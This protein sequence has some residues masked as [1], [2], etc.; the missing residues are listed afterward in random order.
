MKKKILMFKMVQPSGHRIYDAVRCCTMPYDAVKL[1]K[2]PAL[3]GPLLAG[4]RV[5]KIEYNSGKKTLQR[6]K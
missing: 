3:P 5:K 1:G 6:Q 2:N 4:H